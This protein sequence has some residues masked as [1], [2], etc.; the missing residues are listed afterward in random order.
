M[1]SRFT[2]SAAALALAIGAT[3]PFGAAQAQDA[4]GFEQAQIEAFAEAAVIIQAINTE[5]AAQ[6]QSAEGEA[7]RAAIAEQANA[8][9]VAAVEEIE[10]MNVSVYNAIADATREDAALAERVNEEIAALLE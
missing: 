10:G 5:F 6:M 3:A 1:T 9:A 4:G 7:E 8:Q 2:A